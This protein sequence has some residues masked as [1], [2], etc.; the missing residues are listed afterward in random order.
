VHADKDTVEQ[1]SLTTIG[2]FGDDQIIGSNATDILLGLLGADILR[3]RAAND[4]IQGNEGQTFS[5]YNSTVTITSKHRPN[6]PQCY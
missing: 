4:I 1:N 5:F 3:G 2:S 6:S